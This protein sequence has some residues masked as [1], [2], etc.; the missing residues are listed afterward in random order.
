MILRYDFYVLVTSI[1]KEVFG[2][3]LN[4]LKNLSSNAQLSIQK[5]MTVKSLGTRKKI[6]GLINSVVV[7]RSVD[8]F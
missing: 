5:K 6:Q 7:N 8:V 3:N 4:N 2:N 1:P